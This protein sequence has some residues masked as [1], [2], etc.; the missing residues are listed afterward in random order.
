MSNS[1]PVE[2]EVTFLRVT[3]AAVLV[4]CDEIEIWLPREKVQFD[5][6]LDH[7]EKGELIEVT[8]PEWLAY[9]RGLI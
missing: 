5:G 7:C 1:D 2:V 6:L 4:E 8:V 3:S 9:D